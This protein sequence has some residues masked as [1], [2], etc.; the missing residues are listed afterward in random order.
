[1]NRYVVTA[2]LLG[3]TATAA[4]IREVWADDPSPL[5]VSVRVTAGV[6]LARDFN[7]ADRNFAQDGIISGD[8]NDLTPGMLNHPQGSAALV[9]GG[10]DYMLF[11]GLR[12]GATIAYRSQYKLSDH[13]GHPANALLDDPGNITAA[14]GTMT[15]MSYMGTVS[16]DLPIVDGP[17]LPFVTASAGTTTIKAS[18]LQMTYLGLPASFQGASKSNF[19]YTIGGG[20]DYRLDEHFSVALAY[21]YADLGDIV[22]PA[23]TFLAV[24]FPQTSS[25]LKGRLRAN[26]VTLTLR[27]EF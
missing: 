9:G 7:I 19:S 17:A 14:T 15:T 11:D 24:G 10:I 23:Q 22:Y 8:P 25:G 18:P 12:V 13:D 6:S 3:L 20:A 27:C 2:L 21:Q 1:M 4:P 26:E 5:G 16:Y